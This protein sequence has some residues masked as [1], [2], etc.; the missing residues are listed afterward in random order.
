MAMHTDYKILEKR[1][2]EQYK[3]HEQIMERLHYLDHM[4]PDERTKYTYDEYYNQSLVWGSKAP[5][6]AGMSMVSAS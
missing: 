3:T 2:K 5:K 1:I 6:W 4:D